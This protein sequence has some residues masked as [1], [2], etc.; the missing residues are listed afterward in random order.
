M[1]I[2]NVEKKASIEN[3]RIIYKQTNTDKFWM[4][5]NYVLIAIPFLMSVILSLQICSIISIGFAILISIISAGVIYSVKNNDKLIIIKGSDI[6]ENKK[7]VRKVGQKLGW[8][9]EPHRKSHT[10][11][12]RPMSMRHNYWE[13]TMVVLYENNS[14]YINSVTNISRYLNNSPFHW[15]GNRNEEKNF[16]MEF[17]SHLKQH[18]L[19]I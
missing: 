17:K 1:Y 2:N 4:I 18:K 15:F 5:F 10:F 12:T 19:F 16:L 3:K 6:A 13:R 7:I 11:L 9:V 8:R 14:I